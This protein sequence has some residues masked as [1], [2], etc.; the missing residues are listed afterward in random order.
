VQLV[1]FSLVFALQLALSNIFFGAVFGW[2]WEQTESMPLVGWMH[3]WYDLT[4]DTMTLLL[5]GY[6]STLWASMLTLALFSGFG[7][8]LLNRWGKEESVT[9]NTLF[10]FPALAESDH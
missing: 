8:W 5:V 3:Q 1:L 9:L 7:Y 6:G 4:R 2:I 10:K